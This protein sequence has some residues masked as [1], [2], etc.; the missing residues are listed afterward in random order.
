MLRIIQSGSAAQAK[1]YYTEGLGREDYYVGP[2]E[3]PGVW[4]GR[5]AERLGLAGKVEA[6]Q[7]RL[8][9][10][11]QHPDGSGQLTARNKANRRVGYDFNFH[12][13]KGVS[14]AYSV[15]GD[16]LLLEAVQA[17]VEHTMERMEG[18]VETRVRIGGKNETRQTGNL[19]WAS[20]LHKTAR[21]VDGVPDPHL[22]VH[23]FVFNATF[24]ATENRWKAAELAE[25]K[26]NAP[27]FEAIFHHQLETNVRALG[28]ATEE[29]G[30]RWD[31]ANV[32]P[33]ICA[34]YSRRSKEIKSLAEAKGVTDI[35]ALSNLGAATRRSK[36]SSLS[37]GEVRRN[38]EERISV[39][40]RAA[41]VAK[42]APVLEPIEDDTPHSEGGA[43][44]PPSKRGYSSRATKSAVSLALEHC[45]ERKSVQTESH[46]IASAL[47]FARGRSTETQLT[48]E[49]RARDLIRSKDKNGRTVVTRKDILEEEQHL[50]KQSRKGR[51]KLRALRGQDSLSEGPTSD[52]VTHLLQSK[53]RVTLLDTTASIDIDEALSQLARSCRR[54][55]RH[56]SVSASGQD[57]RRTSG[58]V[59]AL[60]RDEKLQRE[61]RGG[62]IWVN[63]ASRLG[64]KDALALLELAEKKHC[65]VILAG[66]LK[67]HQTTRR[68][69]AM[70]LL[71]EHGG[72]RTQ[73]TEKR[74][75]SSIEEKSIKQ[76]LAEGDVTG[77]FSM[78]EQRGGIFEASRDDWA[79]E[80]AQRFKD[81]VRRKQ[82]CVAVT[83]SR[84]AARALAVQLREE[85]KRLGV[86][87]AKERTFERMTRVQGSSA[88]FKDA[89][90]YEAGQ[91][92][93]F[94]QHVKGFRAGE[95]YTVVGRDAFGN[96][97]ARK[98][99]FIEALPLKHSDRYEVYTRD[100]VKFSVG[101][102]IRI[103]RSGYAKS[104]TLLSEATGGSKR[105]RVVAGS[106]RRV[107]GFTLDGDIK[108]DS[109]VVIPK[110]FGHWEHGLCATSHELQGQRVDRVVLCAEIS[111]GSEVL[112]VANASARKHLSVFTEDSAA[113]SSSIW[114]SRQEQ[115]A[116]ALYA[117]A[118]KERRKV[119]A[120]EKQRD[121]V[122]DK[123]N[124]DRER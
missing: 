11:N 23:S 33:D 53:D 62:V 4:G 90:L 39:K 18:E 50:I 92:V 80:L 104:K 101:E 59:A 41:I 38:W 35:E 97:L 105:H 8:L 27:F 15:S 106:T 44:S 83:A 109:G 36:K 54:S 43:G 65:R 21:P 78:L 75:S 118:S 26:S 67:H 73:R 81:P 24:D 63:E 119:E 12:C 100:E 117:D 121:K 89:Q 84:K 114:Q 17:A 30:K 113:L 103:S 108:L 31:I 7:F 102:H 72:F 1:R 69:T 116:S 45:F 29:R 70:H 93:Q 98:G 96:V 68:G 13:P 79:A 110:D 56:F 25:T 120:I 32:S 86:I 112:Q 16:E 28:Y 85:L 49:V 74:A 76:L 57:A 51:G 91:V 111:V 14:V 122:R 61:V 124:H 47:H 40:E 52:A 107:A 6:E 60:L 3:L 87:S 37:F 46:V 19:A 58:T 48:Q 64:T 71:E 94:R 55:V 95:R 82:S 20:F 99:G 123:D 77:G 9:C 2:E 88:E 66:N 34:R 5:G 42:P 10:E 22:H 115:T